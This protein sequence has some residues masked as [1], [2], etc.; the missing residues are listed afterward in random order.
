[1]NILS[2]AAHAIQDQ[3]EITITTKLIGS[4]QI[5]VLIRDTGVGMSEE[6]REKMFDPFFTTKVQGEGTGLGMSIA[7]G[8]IEKHRG[9]IQVSSKLGEGTEFSIQL[10]VHQVG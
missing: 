7:Y 6:T 8:V 10:P 5:Q 1:M 4:D 2:N 3:G 9:K